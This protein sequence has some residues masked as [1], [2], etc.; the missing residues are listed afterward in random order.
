MKAGRGPRPRPPHESR[1]VDPFQVT[2]HPRQLQT[3]LPPH[4]IPRTVH[5]GHGYQFDPPHGTVG[6]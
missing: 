5:H 2:G 6:K 4:H 1:R 3:E